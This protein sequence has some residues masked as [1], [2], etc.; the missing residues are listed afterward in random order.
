MTPPRD[1]LFATSKFARRLDHLIATVWRKGW[2]DK[3]PLDPDYLWAI[4]SKGYSPEDETSIRSAEEVSDFRERL[5]K[6]CQSEFL[7]LLS[8]EPL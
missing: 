5:A 7:Y 3:P 1:S 8:S 4:G 2:D 6:L